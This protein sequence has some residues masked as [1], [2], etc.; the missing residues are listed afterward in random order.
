VSYKFYRVQL[1]YFKESGKYYTSGEYTT[2]KSHMHEISAEVDEMFAAGKRPGLIDGT[3]DF[4]TLVEVPAH[5]QSFPIWKP[6]AGSLTKED[7]DRL[8]ELTKG[9][10]EEVL[11]QA[12]RIVIDA[13]R[14]N[15]LCILVERL[16]RLKQ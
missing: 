14:V 9:F 13:G 6:R 3:H 1:A 15:Y 10:V 8:L 4:G 12:G 16:S 5:P 2:R 11:P 7:A